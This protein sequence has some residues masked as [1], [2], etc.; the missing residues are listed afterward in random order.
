MHRFLAPVQACVEKWPCTAG[1][2]PV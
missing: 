1:R 2:H